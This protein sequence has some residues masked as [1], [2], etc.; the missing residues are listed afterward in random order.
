MFGGVGKS[1][2]KEHL[3]D[4]LYTKECILEIPRGDAPLAP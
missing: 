1:A 4:I 2:F 3:E